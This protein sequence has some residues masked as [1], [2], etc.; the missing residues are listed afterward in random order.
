MQSYKKN[1]FIDSPYLSSSPQPSPLHPFP[2]Y[3]SL[4]SSRLV[5]RENG[6]PHQP[7]HVLK[8]VVSV[9]LELLVDDV[10]FDEVLLE[11][12]GCPTTKRC[13]ILAIYSISYGNN[14]IKI[15]IWYFSNYLSL[16]LYSNL[17]IFCTS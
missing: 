12:G 11:N 4:Q 9:E 1:R 6:T 15:L 13:C 5:L 7:H 10:A 17:C 3:G 2:L 16:S 8:L 14:H